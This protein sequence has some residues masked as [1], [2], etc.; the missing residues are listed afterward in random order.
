VLIA[1][2]V[3]AQHPLGEEH[4]DQQ[5]GGQ[6]RLHDHQRRQ[7]QGQ[8]LQREAQDRQSR[9]KQPARPSEQAPGKRQAQMLLVGRL[10]GVRRLE[11][12]P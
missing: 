5:A 7:Q 9:A 3:L 10:L 6:R 8:D 1:A 12:D 11:G 4:Q 2:R